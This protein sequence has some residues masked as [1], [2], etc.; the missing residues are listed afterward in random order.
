M[1][2][3]SLEIADNVLK[4]SDYFIKNPDGETPWAEPWAQSAYLHYYHVLNLKRLEY[5]FQQ[6]S[7]LGFFE[8]IE[9]LI[10]YGAGLGAATLCA[11]SLQKESQ[12]PRLEHHLIEK[13]TFAKKMASESFG[14]LVDLKWHSQLSDLKNLTKTNMVFVFSYS[15]TELQ[16]IPTEALNAEALIFV[17][18]AT[19][20]DGRLLMKLRE[21]LLQKGFFAWAPCVHQKECPLLHQS[22]TDWCHHR[23]LNTPD[24][25]FLEIEK[26]LPIK[27]KTLTFS[28]LLVRKR[29]PPAALQNKIRVI[30]DPLVEKG[31]VRM[32]ICRN[33]EREYLSWLTRESTP[34]L[35]ER[36][37]LIAPPLSFEKKGNEL[38]PRS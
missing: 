25:K 36:G 23:I 6:A 9:K 16:Q 5:V 27:N 3:D 7:T 2:V 18:P 15:L 28:Y 19:R 8:Q 1:T 38:R 20:Q 4:L 12:L 33:T 14:D 17:E 37:Q 29:P 22:K 35:P 32:A 31:K 10:D 34:N 30:G 21:Q 26:H 13:N 24:E 11:L